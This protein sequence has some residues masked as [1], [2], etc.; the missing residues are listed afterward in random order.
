MVPFGLG[1][2]APLADMDA[3][4]LGPGMVEL[5]KK[6]SASCP[7]VSVRGDFTYEIFKKYGSAERM[8]T[9]PGAPRSSLG[10]RHLG[11]LGRG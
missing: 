10:R 2:Q 1:A 5:V 11:L 7:A 4:E 3:V 8:S 9:I 6:L